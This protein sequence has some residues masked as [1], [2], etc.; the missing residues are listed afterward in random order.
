MKIDFEKHIVHL[1]NLFIRVLNV[2]CF[3]SILQVLSFPM[4]RSVGLMLRVV[5]II[6][7][8]LGWYFFVRGDFKK[9]FQFQNQE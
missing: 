9:P 5:V 4:V 3:L 1:V 6:G 2:R 8:V 7:A